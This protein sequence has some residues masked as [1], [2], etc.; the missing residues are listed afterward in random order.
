[1]DAHPDPHVEYPPE[2][3]RIVSRHPHL[4]Q[5]PIARFLAAGSWSTGGVFGDERC[6]AT[7]VFVGFRHR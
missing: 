1:M 4:L 2:N 7:V 6:K 3:D 5:E